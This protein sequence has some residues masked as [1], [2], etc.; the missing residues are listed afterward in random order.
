MSRAAAAIAT[1]AK[2]RH[3]LDTYIRVA[4]LV[5]AAA[6]GQSTSSPPFDTAA[7]STAV[8][9][10]EHLLQDL[11][12]NRA[13]PA[14]VLPEN[15]PVAQWAEP[16]L[17][18]G[19]IA[20]AVTALNAVL[21]AF[22]AWDKQDQA[23]GWQCIRGHL[24]AAINVLAMTAAGAAAARAPSLVQFKAAAVEGVAEGTA[25]AAAAA[26]T[27]ADSP[28]CARLLEALLA[29]EAAAVRALARVPGF[30]QR[31][32]WPRVRQAA[33]AASGGGGGC[34]GLAIDAF[35]EE[36]TWAHGSLALVTCLVRDAVVA[37]DVLKKTCA[38]GSSAHTHHQHSRLGVQLLGTL[39][40]TRLVAALAAALLAAPADTLPAHRA[41]ASGD[42]DDDTLTATTAPSSSSAAA[43]RVQLSGLRLLR[44]LAA[45]VPAFGA[46]AVAPL[47]APEV[48]QLQREALRQVALAAGSGGTTRRNSELGATTS[49]SCTTEPTPAATAASVV[50]A[51]VV[52]AVPAATAASVAPAAV[53]SADPAA[54]R[55]RRADDRQGRRTGP[56]LPARVMYVSV[57]AAA[58]PVRQHCGAGGDAA[59]AARLAEQL[60][61]CR[62]VAAPLAAAV[63]SAL[64]TRLAATPEGEPWEAEEPEMELDGEWKRTTREVL[65]DAA[66]ALV[67]VVLF[68]MRGAAAEAAEEAAAAAV[69]EEAEEAE[70]A[71][72][73]LPDLLEMV[74]RLAGMVAA[75]PR[76]TGGM[77]PGQLTA[78]VVAAL[79]GCVQGAVFQQI[80]GQPDIRVLATLPPPTEPVLW[81]QL[82]SETRSRCL[83]QLLPT[84][85]PHSLD[86]LLRA[87]VS[88]QQQQL[89]GSQQGQ[90]QQGQEGQGQQ[91]QEGQGQQGQE[92]QGQ[93]GQIPLEL[94]AALGVLTG[95][96]IRAARQESRRQRRRRQGAQQ[97]H[98]RPHPTCRAAAA[99]AD[100]SGGG[101]GGAATGPGSPGVGC[102]RVPEEL[103][104]LLTAL[105]LMRREG[106]A[107]VGAA[108]QQPQQQQPQQG[109]LGSKWQQ[110]PPH[111]QQPRQQQHTH[112]SQSL[113]RRLGLAC[114]VSELGLSDRGLP[115]LLR[116]MVTSAG[117]GTS[118][119]GC[120]GHH[121]GGG[122]SGAGSAADGD[123]ATVVAQ[124]IA[125]CG[126]A[127]LP[128]MLELVEDAIE[129]LQQPEARRAR[130]RHFA[131]ACGGTSGGGLSSPALMPTADLP[132]HLVG[133]YIARGAAGAVMSAAKHLPPELLVALGPQWLLAALGRL[134]VELKP[135]QPLGPGS[136]SGSPGMWQGSRPQQQTTDAAEAVYDGTHKMAQ[137]VLLMS[138]DER[139]LRGC[140]PGWLWAGA[141]RPQDLRPAGVVLDSMSLAALRQGRGCYTAESPNGPVVMVYEKTGGGGGGGDGGGGGGG[142]GDTGG[143]SEAARFDTW[144]WEHHEQHGRD[145]V[146]MARRAAQQGGGGME[147]SQGRAW[148]VLEQR[149][150]AGGGG[151][152]GAVMWPPRRLR[153]CDNPCCGNF[154]GAREA[155][156]GYRKCA[157]C[158]AVRYCCADCQRQHWPQ[159]KGECGG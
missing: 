98:Q 90:G 62:P 21:D 126:A 146:A 52:S 96:L 122:G 89:Q 92:G 3:A 143:V 107:S 45:A 158:R 54:Q 84:D 154:G 100:C 26:D 93:Q 75:V 24:T 140:V 48:G 25:D 11:L 135:R 27:G 18:S 141:L 132:T 86:A 43:A 153:L 128:Y 104:V 82:S 117:A 68:R 144:R 53:V 152:A 97:P 147:A 127:V 81:L 150:G 133:S 159:H 77:A 29:G 28:L 59:A 145:V 69:A 12:R 101:G 30:V 50:P 56:P 36:D 148:E 13:F 32:A 67:H 114:F 20:C 51:A 55:P 136:G 125:A 46:A 39:T 57:M 7:R 60:L 63:V 108:G 61:P 116:E 23:A 70:E 10:L 123:A 74:A 151:A 78:M 41:A 34:G 103:G 58:D 16:M 19:A 85:L 112:T 73:C 79:S 2:H 80:G 47:D 76:A 110:Q 71:E 37:V 105:K 149:A 156:L 83:Q 134:M 95:D 118:P 38:A 42:G 113:M 6:S 106:G 139:T 35:A 15:L 9:E 4:K 17:R 94:S 129:G 120:G 124:A 88:Q 72:A 142:G 130:R 157:R 44:Q 102:W 131:A 115:L 1:P 49:A 111:P 5:H 66:A 31:H 137:T 99:A 91:G 121:G 119:A 22:E 64:H 109:P 65:V 14:A 138:A 155:E 33:A 87:A 40:R 8:S